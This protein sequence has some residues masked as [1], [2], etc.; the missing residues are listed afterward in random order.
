MMN[1]L[2]IITF[3][4]LNL[5]VSNPILASD[6]SLPEIIAKVEDRQSTIKKEIKDAVFM[7]EAVYKES[8]KHGKVKK[9]LIIKKR[10][11]MTDNGIGDEEYLS[12]RANGREL[13]GDE[14]QH[15]I[16]EWKKKVGRQHD[17]KMPMTTEAEGAYDY[18]L[19]G[20]N[21]WNGMG[22]WIVGF[23]SKKQIDGYINGYAYISMDSY[24]ILNVV[25]SP[26]KVPWVI[27]DMT[28]LLINSKVQGYWM[29]MEF[30]LDMEIRLG[31]LVELFYREIEIEEKYSDYKFN[32]NL[33]YPSYAS[34]R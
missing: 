22:V 7:A 32:K 23:R 25:F 31:L 8:D 17:T 18:Y 3:I 28:M 20:N 11:H 19:I 30:K 12:I 24:D 34:K 4:F 10:V 6:I 9:K 29:P 13:S 26:A 27:K 16:N 1:R 33:Q 14:L 21:D 5:F 15:E 2:F